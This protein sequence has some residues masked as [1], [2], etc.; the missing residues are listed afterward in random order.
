[1]TKL[2]GQSEDILQD[3]IAVLREL[4][5][6]VC[7]EGKVDFDKLKQVLGEYTDDSA[8]RYNFTWNGKGQALRTGFDGEGFFGASQPRQIQQ[9]RH[10]G[11]SHGIGRQI[12]RKAHGQADGA[13]VVPIEALAAAKAGV[14]RSQFHLLCPITLAQN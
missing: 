14:A 9:G 5:P 8:D 4:F 12:H 10:F 6:E 11:T 7:C 2:N 13:A 3:N 1:M